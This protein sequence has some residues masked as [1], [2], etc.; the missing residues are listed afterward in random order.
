MIISRS[1]AQPVH[2]LNRQVAKSALLFTNIGRPGAIGLCFCC[3]IKLAHVSFASSD[4]SAG[5]SR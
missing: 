3:K 2:P 5:R 4:K 1:G